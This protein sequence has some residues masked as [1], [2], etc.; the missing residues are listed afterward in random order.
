MVE[1]AITGRKKKEERREEIV[2]ESFFTEHTQPHRERE[3]DRE[4]KR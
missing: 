4:R 1:W 2:K 3:I